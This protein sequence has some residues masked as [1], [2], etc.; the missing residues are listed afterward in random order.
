MPKNPAV[1]LVIGLVVCA[2]VAYQ[3]FA[4]GEAQ[5]QGL[6]ILEWVLLICGVLGVVGSAIQLA[7]QKS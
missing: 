3:L 6:V 5:S 2:W 1:R 7:G 4:P